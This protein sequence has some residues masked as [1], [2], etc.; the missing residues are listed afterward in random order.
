MTPCTMMDDWWLVFFLPLPRQCK[1][2]CG[3]TPELVYVVQLE[4][5]WSLLLPVLMQGCS[6]V[7]FGSCQEMAGLELL[8]VVCG[9]VAVAAFS[10]LLPRWPCES[11]ASPW[12]H[13]CLHDANY[14]QYYQLWRPDNHNVELFFLGGVPWFLGGLCQLLLW[15]PSQQ[16]PM[17]Q[18]QNRLDTLGG[19]ICIRLQILVADQSSPSVYGS[20][21]FRPQLVL[22]MAGCYYNQK[23]SYLK[24][25]STA[26]NAYL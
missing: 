25:T 22:L 26:P 7:L 15:R 9:L 11:G 3:S 14:R 16:R 19:L 20:R 6:L 4:G 13:Y 8:V 2:C 21:R 24:L 12:R 17:R 1:T 5:L 18:F 10:C 23:S